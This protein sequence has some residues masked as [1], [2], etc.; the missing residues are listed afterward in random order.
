MTLRWER[1][2][3]TINL[4]RGK[5]KKEPFWTEWEKTEMIFGIRKQN[6]GERE[7]ENKRDSFGKRANQQRPFFLRGERQRKKKTMLNVQERERTTTT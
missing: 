2:R 5:N 3:K 7:M 4:K 1:E 6:V